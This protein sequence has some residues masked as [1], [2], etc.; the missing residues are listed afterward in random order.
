MVMW[1]SILHI[2]NHLLLVKHWIHLVKLI[3]HVQIL[4][5]IVIFGLLLLKLEC[6]LHMT[7][8]WL[9]SLSFI[10]FR[11]DFASLLLFLF[12]LLEELLLLLLQESCL[13]LI[14]LLLNGH[15]LSLIN[16][17]LLGWHL[18]HHLLILYKLGLLL[19]FKLHLL[20]LQILLLLFSQ[21]VSRVQISLY[22]LRLR[23]IISCGFRC[24]E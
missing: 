9:I 22:S 8:S 13:I 7:C 14:L 16:L 6:R 21:C 20:L 1:L 18:R 3:L 11:F 12:L 17:L 2:M 10:C 4:Y 24:I 5:L 23:L 19:L 15:H